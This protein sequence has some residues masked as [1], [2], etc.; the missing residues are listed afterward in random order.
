MKRFSTKNWIIAMLVSAWVVSFVVGFLHGAGL[1]PEQENPIFHA[2]TDW[3][4]VSVILVPLSY[5]LAKIIPDK[6]PK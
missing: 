4:V 6:W 5:L 1:F 3:V 2:T